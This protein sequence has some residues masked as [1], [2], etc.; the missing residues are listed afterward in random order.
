MSK[1]WNMTPEERYKKF[2]FLLRYGEIISDIKIDDLHIR[3]IS[4]NKKKYR[5]IMKYG[6]CL[7][8]NEMII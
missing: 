1:F 2:K 8:V 6:K 7:H 3:I 4:Y 5:H